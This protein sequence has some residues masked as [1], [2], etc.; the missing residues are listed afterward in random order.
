MGRWLRVAPGSLLLQSR[1]ARV[2]KHPIVM[3]TAYDAPSARICD[4]AGVDVIL[5][6]DSLA[7]VVLG[8]DD[9]LQVTIA[10]ME[11][12]VGCR[13]AHAVRARWSSATCRG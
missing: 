8:Y 4:A 10:D 1:R 9:T 7:N 3:V 11:H 13:G 12:H 5:V 2:A 6:G